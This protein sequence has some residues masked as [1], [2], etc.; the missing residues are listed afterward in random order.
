MRAYCDLGEIIDPYVFAEPGVVADR[1]PPRELHAKA[2]LD[3]YAAA[4]ARA[5]HAQDE[6]A[7]SRSGNLRPDREPLHE[8]P[9]AFDPARLSARKATV[10]IGIKPHRVF[11]L[12]EADACWR[13]SAVEQPSVNFEKLSGDAAPAEITLGEALPVAPRHTLRL[14]IHLHE[15]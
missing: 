4:D 5:E 10:V 8:Y 3:R 11:R 9:E 13:W 1:Q 12:S 7:M 14:P 6:A 15:C 2:R